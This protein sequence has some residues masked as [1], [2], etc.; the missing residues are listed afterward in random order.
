MDAVD[1]S[2]ITTS[3]D[4]DVVTQLKEFVRASLTEE[5]DA[6]LFVCP[7]YLEDSIRREG[8]RMCRSFNTTKFPTDA[9]PTSD[10]AIARSTDTDHYADREA[11]HFWVKTTDIPVI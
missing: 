4:L 7:T 5:A 10:L 1:T 2:T 8:V 9:I 11:N 3:P 6:H